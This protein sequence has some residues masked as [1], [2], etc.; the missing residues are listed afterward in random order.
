MQ[1]RRGHLRKPVEAQEHEM[2]NILAGAF[3][4]HGKSWSLVEKDSFP[5][6]EGITKLGYITTARE[7]YIYMDPIN[8]TYIFDLYGNNP[9]IN[10][11]EANKLILWALRLSVC[12]SMIESTSGEDNLR[13]DILTRR[14]GVS[15]HE[16]RAS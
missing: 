16:L 14:G 13:A 2:L 15:I 9:G 5:V 11:H 1:M 4:G 12:R 10:W 8:Q 7:A 6:M 3:N